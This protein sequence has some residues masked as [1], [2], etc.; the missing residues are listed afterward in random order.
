MKKSF[1]VYLMVV[2]LLFASG[3]ARNIAQSELPVSSSSE[4]P[5]LT[6]DEA[7][8]WQD[9]VA[10]ME[11]QGVTEGNLKTLENSGLPQTEIMEMTA[12]E[13]FDKLEEIRAIFHQNKMDMVRELLADWELVAN[14]EQFVY[15]SQS[16]T[17]RL[18]LVEELIAAVERED[19]ASVMG[20]MLGN[21]APIIFE[22][23]QDPVEGL[24]LWKHT[25]IDGN[26]EIESMQT[27]IVDIVDDDS[28]FYQFSSADGVELSIPRNSSVEEPG[29]IRSGA[30]SETSTLADLFPTLP[31]TMEIKDNALY[32]REEQRIMAEL[33][34]VDEVKDAA[35]PF[36]H[37]DQLYAEA[38]QME[39]GDWGGYPGK[40][41]RLQKEITGG[42]VGGFENH[43]VYCIQTGESML[44]ITFHPVRG[45][46]GISSQRETFEAILNTIQV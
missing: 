14:D 35:V 18:E 7:T 3:C 5:V 43:I 2:V 46:G 29:E 1:V 27:T 17:Q 10:E 26:G 20:G 6:S 25:D 16:A 44:V 45:V 28:L 40:W 31:D 22:L 9:F 4:E 19:S 33:T 41:Y 32:H 8:L 15:V 38:V 34:S 12:R 37:Y 13:I 11:S 21:P 30:L 23:V 42:A 39:E 24:T 36:A